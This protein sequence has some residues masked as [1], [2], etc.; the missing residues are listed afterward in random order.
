MK[1]SGASKEQNQDTTNWR[2]VVKQYNFPDPK[3]SIWQLVNSVVPFIGIWI[4]MVYSLEWSYWIT[5]ALSVLAAGFM[6]R[7]FIIFH[8]CGHK[9]FFKSPKWNE[10]IGFFTGLFTFTPYHKWHRSHNKHHATVGNLDKRGTGDVTTMTVE[11]YQASSKGKQ[12]FYRLY[13]HP[14]IMLG[15][16]APYIFLLQNR[17]YPKNAQPREKRNVWITTI[18]LVVIITGISLWVGFKTFVLIQL[19]TFYLSA[20][21]GIWL[22]YFQHQYEDVHWYRTGDWKYETV[23]L[24]GSSFYKLPRVLQWFSGNI[25]FHHVHHLSA[26]IPNYKLE[27]AHREN[28]LFQTVNPMS[29]RKS[30]ESLKLRLWD[31]KNNKLISFKEAAA[32]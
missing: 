1:A 11:E 2:S 3:Q 7:I 28:P 19:P 13:R 5:L 25:G 6:V 10:W 8:D 32:I 21:G 4:L 15:I 31:E 17:W 12:L 18:T 22:F 29:L 30:L 26:R 27:R 9:S 14:I 24:H 23:A 16:G 20:I